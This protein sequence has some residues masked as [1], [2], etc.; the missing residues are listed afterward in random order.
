MGEGELEMH[1]WKLNE[2]YNRIIETEQR[3][4]LYNIDDAEI[5]IVAYGIAARISKGAAKIGEANGLKIGLV[6]PITLW[7]FPEKA[8]KENITSKV[9]KILVVEMNLG[10]MIEDVKLSVNGKVPVEFLGKPGGT[11][12]TPEEIYAY[13]K[14][15]C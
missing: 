1:N 14:K 2:K 4:E 12:F 8:I 5:V 15:L 13:A 6:R 7:P 10:Q 9:V 3:V 11:I